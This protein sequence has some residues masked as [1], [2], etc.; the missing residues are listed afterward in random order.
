M[1][2]LTP[3]EIRVVR[4]WAE[5]GASSPF[6]QEM[7]LISRLKNNISNRE[8]K[9]SARE[10]E[11]VLHWAELD[12]KGHHGTEQFLLEQEELLINKIEAY[13]SERG[14]NLFNP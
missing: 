2:N 3:S 13:L 12:T 14:D 1:L 10:L 4:V 6:P 9:L 7:S 11:I 8:M 5:K